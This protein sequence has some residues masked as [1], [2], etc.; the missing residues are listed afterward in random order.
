MF[1]KSINLLFLFTMLSS[2]DGANLDHDP[3]ALPPCG[4]YSTCTSPAYNYLPHIASMTTCQ[5]Y[6]LSDPQ[7]HHYS[8]NY[9][10]ASPTYRHC[11]LYTRCAAQ[12]GS[13]GWVS[14]HRH[15]QPANTATLNNGFFRTRVG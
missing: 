9:S 3:P 8:Y 15:C 2:S 6:C 5:S 1:I 12:H 7:C 10:P 4:S 14:G 13:S 11:Y